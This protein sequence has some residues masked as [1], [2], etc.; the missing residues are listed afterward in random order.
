MLSEQKAWLHSYGKRTEV[1]RI[2]EPRG[3]GA[4]GAVE[5][6]H[7]GEARLLHEFEFSQ[8][9]PTVC[10]PMRARVAAGDETDTELRG[11]REAARMAVEDAAKVV[12]DQIAPAECGG[13][14]DLILHRGERR[15]PREVEIAELRE[16]VVVDKIAV[17]DRIDARGDAVRDTVVARAMN[18]RL[19][20]A[21]ARGLGELRELGRGHLRLR[22]DHALLEIDDARCDQFDPVRAGGDALGNRCLG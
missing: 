19:L 20:A 17:L 21:R 15:H 3:A 16:L 13:V 22:C 12:A 9:T 11:A 10:Y 1:F 2:T 8:K 5:H 4:R 18:H 7:G 14:I 6:L